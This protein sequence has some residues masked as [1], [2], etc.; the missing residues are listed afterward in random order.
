MPRSSNCY[1]SFIFPLRRLILDD[2]IRIHSKSGDILREDVHREIGFT[3]K[4][5][6][7]HKTLLLVTQ[8]S[9]GACDFFW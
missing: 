4:V 2:K 1:S 5:T 6:D 9:V 8:D 7:E 3:S